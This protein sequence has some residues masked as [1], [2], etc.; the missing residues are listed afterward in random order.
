M[1]SLSNGTI[2]FD[3]G[4]HGYIGSSSAIF[5]K[6]TEILLKILCSDGNKEVKTIEKIVCDSLRQWNFNYVN[7]VKIWDNITHIS[8]FAVS[9]VA[10]CRPFEVLRKTKMRKSIRVFFYLK[11]K[12]TAFHKPSFRRKINIFS[13]NA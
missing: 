13:S 9:T 6:V 5:R 1:I 2:T 8:I 3:I 7:M 10:E 11:E 4:G 12:S